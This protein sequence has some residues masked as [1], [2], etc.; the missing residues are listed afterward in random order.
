MET[1]SFVSERHLSV[2]YV[3]DAKPEDAEVTK[4]YKASYQLVNVRPEALLTDAIGKHDPC[5]ALR[6]QQNLAAHA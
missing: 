5:I 4:I 6:S 3:G 1:C 2:A